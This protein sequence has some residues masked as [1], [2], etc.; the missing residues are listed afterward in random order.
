MATITSILITAFYLKRFLG[1]YAIVVPLLYMFLDVNYSLRIVWLVLRQV[2]RRLKGVQ[3]IDALEM[4][5]NIFYVLP[6]DLDV[7]LHM[8]N[9]R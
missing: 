3:A 1:V 4:T 9:A 2:A 6:T 5:E 8:N 7:N